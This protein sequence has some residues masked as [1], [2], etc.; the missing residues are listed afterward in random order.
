MLG[1]PVAARLLACFADFEFAST[2][3]SAPWLPRLV[4]TA[5][6]S[7]FNV[8]SDGQGFYSFPDLP[9]GHYDLTIPAAGFKTLRTTN[10]TIDTDAALKID[11]VLQIGQRSETVTVEATAAATGAQVDTVAIH[12]GS[13]LPVRR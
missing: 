2:R 6:E 3:L 10:L 4:N 1:R 9:V 12:L 11:A 5:L 13:S 8:I 7:K